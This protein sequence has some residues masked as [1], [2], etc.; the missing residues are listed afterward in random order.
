MKTILGGDED[1]N[2]AVKLYPKKSKYNNGLGLSGADLE[3]VADIVARFG[4]QSEKN[5]LDSSR[6]SDDSET[7]QRILEFARQHAERESELGQ[8]L[9]DSRAGRL[10]GQSMKNESRRALEQDGK[11]AFKK[12]INIDARNSF[13]AR[14]GD[15]WGDEP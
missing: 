7:M 12:M 3:K 4:S 13:I 1:V 5:L 9:T 8:E 15:P 14:R 2:Y 11:E 10:F 6:M